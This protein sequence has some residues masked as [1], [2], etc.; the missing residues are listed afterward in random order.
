M[1]ASRRQIF[2]ITALEYSFLGSLAA[3]AGILLSLGAGWALSRYVF[4]ARFHPQWSNIL[5]VLLGVSAVT[6]L[7][8]LANSRYIVDKAPL[9]ILRDE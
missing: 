3:L 9:E 2:A 4:E 6:L 8:G 5:L 1:G 7:I